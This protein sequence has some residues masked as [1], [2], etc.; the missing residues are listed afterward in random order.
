MPDYIVDRFCLLGPVEKQIERL[1]ELSE[2]GV[3]QFALYLMHDNIPETLEAYRDKI[4]PAA[5]DL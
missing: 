5:A 3:D 4:I 2:I 1:V